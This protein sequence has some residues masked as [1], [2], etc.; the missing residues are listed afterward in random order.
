MTVCYFY[1]FQF[2][3]ADVATSF[4]YKVFISIFYVSTWIHTAHYAA[5]AA[6]AG[7]RMVRQLTAQESTKEER[8]GSIFLLFARNG[9]SQN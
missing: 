5:A 4:Y 1:A 3:A 8:K 2:T 7:V 6:G 9:I